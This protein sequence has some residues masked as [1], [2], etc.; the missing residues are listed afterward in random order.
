MTTFAIANSK[1]GVGKS[2][3][4]VQIACEKAR[5]GRDVLVIN[6]DRQKSSELAMLNRA[7]SDDFPPITC[8][9][10]EHGPE[11]LAAHRAMKGKY[12]DIVIDV[13]G[14]D[15][16][17]MRAALAVCDVALVPF[18]PGS[19]EVW[20]LE[21]MDELLRNALS[22]R[23]PFPIYA[24][25][26]LAEAKAQSADNADAMSA[27]DEYPVYQQLPFVMVRRKPFASAA[28]QGL[29][30]HEVRPKNPKACHELDK[31]M[32]V[33][34]GRPAYEVADSLDPVDGDTDAA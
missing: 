28:G 33:L 26:N 14:R 6:G 1:G 21:E 3:I 29:S 11:L 24:L 27:L 17:A 10:Y 4:A 30:V 2:T 23:D 5:Q 34:D 8:V 15:S 13:G 32:Q 31:L 18:A 12:D 25:L 19:F 9:R 7:Q 16:S 22:T 20:A